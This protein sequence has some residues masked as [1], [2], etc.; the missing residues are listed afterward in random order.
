MRP[1]KPNEIAAMASFLIPRDE[2]LL[3]LGC[4]T[5]FRISEL[6]GLRVGDLYAGREVR[7]E[8]V[9]QRSSLKNGRGVRRKKIRS[10]RV[11]LG[12]S[13][14][15]KLGEYWAV[16]FGFVEPKSECLIFAS[17]FHGRALSRKSFWRILWVAAQ[18]AGI[19]MERIGTHS[20]RKSFAAAVYAAT[21]HDLLATQKLLGH[22]NPLTT[23]SYLEFDEGRLDQVVLSLGGV[24]STSEDVFPAARSSQREL[25]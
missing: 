8:L 9:I 23:A 1:F 20:M 22:Q 13:I 14:R 16:R 5:G 15:K 24:P 10:R 6:L 12:E 18:K 11:V 17:R 3:H 21:G 4:A 25:G 19:P 7:R 2:L